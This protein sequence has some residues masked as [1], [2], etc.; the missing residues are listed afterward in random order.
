MRPPHTPKS[1]DW[2]GSLDDSVGRFC[3]MS[4]FYRSSALLLTTTL[5]FLIATGSAHAQN[6]TYTWQNAIGTWTNTT[7][8]WLGSNGSTTGPQLTSTT[9]NTDTA[10]FSNVGSGNNTVT[11]TSNRTVYGLV[12]SSTANAYTFTASNRALDVM[13]GGGL[14][15]NSTQVQTFNMLVQNASGNGQWSSVAG[16]SLLF[17]SGV[18]LTTS[19]NAQ[20]RTLTLAGAGTITVNSIIANGGTATAGAITVTSNGSTILSGNNTYGGVTTMNSIGGG[21][22]TLSG[23]NSGAAGGVTLTAGTLNINHANALGTGALTISAGVT[24]ANTSGA[25][26]TNLGNNAITFNDFTFGTANSTSSSNLDLGTGNVIMSSTRTIT[27]AGTN[28]TLSM[29]FGNFTSIA[30]F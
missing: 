4:P 2:L 27:L 9:N 22:L 26:I 5:A 29:G 6:V 25:A 20:S 10:L 19:G 16:G 18:S 14:V 21:T 28:S 23:N 1:G 8:A 7:T 30:S 12:L 3:F 15:N 17:N 11:L 24:I 13:S